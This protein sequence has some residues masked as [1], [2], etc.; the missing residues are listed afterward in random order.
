M[1]KSTL[2]QRLMQVEE[3]VARG[4][5]DLRRQRRIV[6]LLERQG[7]HRAAAVKALLE[8]CETSQNDLIADRD[9]IERQLAEIAG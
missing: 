8:G 2:A 5:L 9:R 3:H 4:E 1:D 7:S 6:E